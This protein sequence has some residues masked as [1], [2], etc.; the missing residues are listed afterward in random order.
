VSTVT[1]ETLPVGEQGEVCARGYAVMKGYAAT[2]KHSDGHSPRGW[3]H[4][5][6]LAHA[7]DGCI[8]LTGAP[9]T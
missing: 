8:H 7:R 2:P 1:G 3:L 6:D 4:T 9:A 5:G